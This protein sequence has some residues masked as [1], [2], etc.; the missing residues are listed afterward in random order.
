MSWKKLALLALLGVIASSW[1]VAQTSTLTPQ[2]SKNLAQANRTATGTPP[3]H[4]P[5]TSGGPGAV[6]IPGSGTPSTRTSTGTN[7]REPCWEVAGISKSAMEQRRA[8][9]MQS[10]QE[11][12]AVCADAALSPAQKQTRIREIHQQERQQIDGLI[13]PA[14]REAMHACQQERGGGMG[15]GNLVGG[16]GGE[17]P[18]GV[19]S[20]VPRNRIPPVGATI[21]KD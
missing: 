19:R 18:C 9:S 10:R 6:S 17:G 1:I 16:G 14:Q 21:P 7:R 4:S 3:V 11:V 20:A 8:I 5:S 15:G 2:R 13:S 12:E